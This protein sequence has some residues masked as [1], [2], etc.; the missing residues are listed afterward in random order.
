MSLVTRCPACSTLFRVAAQQLQARQGTVRCGRCTAVFDGFKDL[1]SLPELP[2]HEIQST[3]GQEPRTPAAPGPATR[4]TPA[5]P[6][7]AIP[8][9]PPGFRFAAAHAPPRAETAQPNVSAESASPRPAP[10]VEH[11][12][13]ASPPLG[14]DA[15][16]LQQAHAAR[17]RGLRAWT[18]GSVLLVV[19]LAAQ[20]AYFYRG[21]LAAHYRPLKPVVVGMCEALDCEV[22]LPQRPRLI[23]IEASD[24]QSID[25]SRPGLIELT[26]TL[27]N[28]AD[29][30]LAYPALDLV[31]TDTR[32]HTLARRVFLPHEYLEP[33]RDADAGFPAKAEITVRLDLDTGDLN[34]AGFRLDLLPA[35]SR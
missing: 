3:P 23:N 9:V 8:P 15:L 17:R 32:E 34:A 26:A 16:F 7:P 25:P 24:L 2:A 30:E 12:V 33:P 5:P 11:G 35:L 1:A 14:A 22:P 21:D 31:L 18:F 19:T 10:R 27:R 4:S 6:P 13:S 29:Y 28:H 20:A